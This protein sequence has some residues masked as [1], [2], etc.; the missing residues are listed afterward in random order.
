MCELKCQ[1]AA[2]VARPAQD[3]IHEYVSDLLNLGKSYVF[4]GHKFH[5]YA[6]RLLALQNPSLRWASK[7]ALPT[8]SVDLQELCAMSVC[9]TKDDAVRRSLLKAKDKCEPVFILLPEHRAHD[10]LVTASSYYMV[11]I[12]FQLMLLDDW[13][14]LDASCSAVTRST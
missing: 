3:F 12:S 6:A 1:A 8:K 2:Y 10:T 9:C 11:M 5:S 7:Y 4:L 14:I 13:M